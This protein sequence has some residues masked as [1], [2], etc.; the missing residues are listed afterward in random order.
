[1]FWD[2][3][4]FL[5]SLM[6]TKINLH[7]LSIGNDNFQKNATF[8]SDE[9]ITDISTDNIPSKLPKPSKAQKIKLEE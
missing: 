7:A 4:Q 5:Q 9:E 6:K 8:S 3:V 1:M 2:K